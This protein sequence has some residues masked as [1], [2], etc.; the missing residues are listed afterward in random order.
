MLIVTPVY[1]NKKS[2]AQIL[3]ANT[4]DSR[5]ILCSWWIKSQPCGKNNW[6]IVDIWVLPLSKDHKPGDTH[7]LRR[8]IDKN[9][10]V[11]PYRSIWIF[12]II[13]HFGERIGPD[14]VWL[15]NEDVPGLAMSRSIGDG[16]ASS[17]GVIPD[18]DIILHNV[19][20]NDRCIVM[21][22]DGVWEQMNN[23]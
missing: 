18:P 11:E 7:E 3:C 14:R 13:D 4:G 20:E 15:R 17:V 2:K 21:A 23:E 9:G 10:R 22:S 12:Q 16:I 19:C 1:G 5:S 8:I 6:I